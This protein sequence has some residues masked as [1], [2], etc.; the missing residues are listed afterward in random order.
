MGWL[1]N[2]GKFCVGKRNEMEIMSD[3]LGISMLVASINDRKF[4]PNATKSCTH[5]KYSDIYG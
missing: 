3:A 5:N 4:S 1:K 2:T